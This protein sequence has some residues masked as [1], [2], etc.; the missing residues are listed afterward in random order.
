MSRVTN[1]PASRTRR[2][3]RLALA[4]GYYGGRSRLFRT[5]TES[6]DRAR[7]MAT[8]HRKTRKRD[9]RALWIVRIS[10]ACRAQGITYTKFMAGLTKAGAKLNRKMISEIALADPQG[11]AAIV[12]LARG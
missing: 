6:V 12:A 1:A 4:K 10:A 3:R 11:F 7:R 8:E 5:A 2:R 9:Y